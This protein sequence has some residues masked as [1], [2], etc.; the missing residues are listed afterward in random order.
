MPVHLKDIAAYTGVSIRTVSN[1]VNGNYERV[2][3]E[4]RALVLEAIKKLNYRPNMAARHLRKG[5]VSILA[6]AFPDL[7]NPYFTDVGYAIA[8]ISAAL[9][10]TVLFDYTFSERERELGVLTG[11]SPHLIDG[12][13]LDSHALDIEDIHNI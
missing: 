12:V 4:T 2:G 9:N 3:P 5:Q 13:I 6:Y 8:T 10:Y 7:S 1:V 11:M